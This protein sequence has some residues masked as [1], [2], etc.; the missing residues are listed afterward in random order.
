M[1]IDRLT[2]THV[3]LD[4]HIEIL[5]IFHQFALFY[6]VYFNLL[7]ALKLGITLSVRIC[8]AKV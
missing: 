5:L 4:I 1:R 6:T 8:T 3:P 2:I 7:L